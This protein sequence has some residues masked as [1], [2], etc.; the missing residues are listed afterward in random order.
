MIVV[1]LLVMLYVLLDA[2]QEVSPEVADRIPVPVV[3]DAKNDGVQDL[4][5]VRLREKYSSFGG[6]CDCLDEQPA[7]LKKCPFV[8]AWNSFLI[9]WR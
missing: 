1:G 4:S 5:I 2:V 3:L 6:V 9:R 7:L 8:T